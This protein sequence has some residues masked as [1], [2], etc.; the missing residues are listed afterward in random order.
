MSE[1]L[2]YVSYAGSETNCTIWHF[3]GW[4]SAMWNVTFTVP[5]RKSTYQL[6]H[7]QRKQVARDGNVRPM[8]V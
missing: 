6:V 7:A 2:F 4:Q 3:L 1:W 5:V 8:S